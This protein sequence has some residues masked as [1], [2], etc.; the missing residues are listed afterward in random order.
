MH[1]LIRVGDD[2]KYKIRVKMVLNDAFMKYFVPYIIK[3]GMR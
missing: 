2:V 1:V 3:L